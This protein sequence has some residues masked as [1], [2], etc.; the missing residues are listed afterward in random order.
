MTDFVKWIQVRRE[1]YKNIVSKVQLRLGKETRDLSQYRK[2]YDREFKKKWSRSSLRELISSI[3]RS[4]IVFLGDFHALQQSQ[5][6]HVRI[7]QRFRKNS[8]IGMECL[9]MEAQPLV[10]QFLCGDLGEEEFVNQIKWDKEW[11]FPWEHYRMLFIWAKEN[12]IPIFALNSSK[13]HKLL[14]K[15][16]RVAEKIA[17]IFQQLNIKKKNWHF[18][19]I[20]GELHL[21]QKHLPHFVA[22]KLSRD[23]PKILRVL[24]NIEPIYFKLLESKQENKVDIVKIGSKT[25][26]LQNVP[27]WVKWQN[28]LLFLDQAYDKDLGE[29]EDLTDVVHT[30]TQFMGKELGISIR[31]SH[32]SVYTASDEN[33]WRVL[34]KKISKD[35][36][37]IIEEWVEQNKSFYLPEIPLAYLARTSINHVSIL[38][39]YFMHAQQSHLNQTL[40]DV[41]QNFEQWIWL[42]AW[43][44]FGSKL[45]NPKRKSDTLLDIK[46]S[47]VKTNNSSNLEILRLTLSQKMYEMNFQYRRRFW[48]RKKTTYFQAAALLGGM[49]GEKLF[50]G[51]Q[52]SLIGKTEIKAWMKR[53]LTVSDF[54]DFYY[55]AV[56]KIDRFPQSFN[57]KNDKI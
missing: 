41:K 36:L 2:V 31:T 48:P 43:A 6:S 22:K 44:Y 4:H 57:S 38:A 13:S 9:N 25:F 10:D 29:S 54:P 23:K 7:L 45:M 21:A 12:K 35:K 18:F 30:Y 34:S 47:I 24:Q 55:Q 28:Y 46:S 37:K 33:F 50:A 39:M 26:S 8:V 19:V 20:Y 53:S 17:Q 15:D 49:L 16:K 40:F 51:Y 11:G 14:T 27:P 56:L 42:E 5:K 3:E 1:L 32:L 52:Q